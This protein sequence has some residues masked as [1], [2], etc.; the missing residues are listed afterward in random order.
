MNDFEIKTYG[1]YSAYVEEGW[2]TVKEL[3]KLL[4]LLKST[5]ARQSDAIRKLMEIPK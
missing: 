1:E 4:N 5:N 3:E 2:Y